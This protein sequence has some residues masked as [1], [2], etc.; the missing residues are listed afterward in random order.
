[1]TEV[2]SNFELNVLEEKMYAL[3]VAKGQRACI[4]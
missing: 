4:V 2:G 1:M 3:I